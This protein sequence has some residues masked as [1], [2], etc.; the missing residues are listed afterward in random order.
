MFRILLLQGGFVFILVFVVPSVADLS[1]T[2]TPSQGKVN[3]QTPSV[4]ATVVHDCGSFTFSGSG[5]SL[6]P[7]EIETIR[8]VIS[9]L[10]DGAI[11]HFS[12]PGGPERPI[13]NPKHKGPSSKKLLG[14]IESKTF[15]RKAGKPLTNLIK[16]RLNG[17]FENREEIVKKLR[18]QFGI[19]QSGEIEG[20]ADCHVYNDL[21]SD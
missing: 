16:E 21:G 11:I 9:Y 6:S 3:P 8:E 4:I 7:A 13:N 14:L 19:I 1:N 17:E 12:Y 15:A 20:T 10:Y 5:N 2:S 18:T